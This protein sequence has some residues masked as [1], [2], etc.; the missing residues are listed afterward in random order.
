MY[1]LIYLMVEKYKKF[2]DNLPQYILG[3]PFYMVWGDKNSGAFIGA[4]A[5]N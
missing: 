2:R 4:P 3:V 5:S 1:L